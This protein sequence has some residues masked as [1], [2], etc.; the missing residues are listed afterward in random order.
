VLTASFLVVQFIKDEWRAVVGHFVSFAVLGVHW[1]VINFLSTRTERAT[2]TVFGITMIHCL[3]VALFPFTVKLAVL[4]DYKGWEAAAPILSYANL[5]LTQLT[6]W[7]RV[8]GSIS[9][10]LAE[11]LM[12]G[13]VV[14]T[15]LCYVAYEIWDAFA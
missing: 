2:S 14:L 15:V 9:D 6:L 8:R 12:M 7:L 13:L 11:R 4:G 10:K 1:C 5:S 3:A